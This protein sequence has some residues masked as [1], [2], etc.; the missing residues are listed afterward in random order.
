M[1][2]PTAAQLQF[3]YTSRYLPTSYE[4][5][6][7]ISDSRSAEFRLKHREKPHWQLVTDKL[8]SYP[9]AHREVSPSVHHRTGQ[10]ENNRAEVSHQHTREQ[11]RQLRRF[12]SMAQAQLFLS[13]HSP[14][15][16]LFRVGRLHL[17]AINHRI[18]RSR[19]FVEWQEATCAC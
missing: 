13:V 12:K 17:R 9:A 15:Q 4:H 5:T 6:T 1:K 8:R 3:S 2:G 19:A 11:D 7:R 10:Y 16:N 14:I 18:L